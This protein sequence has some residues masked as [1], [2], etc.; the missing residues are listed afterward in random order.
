M[1]DWLT[2]KLPRE[3]L[4]LEA[5]G[6]LEDRAGRVM[7][8]NPDGTIAWRCVMRESVRSDS[9]QLVVHANGLDVVLMGSPARV[10][11]SHN[12]FGSGDIRSCA[13]DMIAFASQHT[14]VTLPIDLSLWRCSRTDVTENY[15]LGSAAEVRQALLFLRSAE[16][17]RYQVRTS[18]E[19]V[20]WSVQSR[21]RSAKAYHK[22]PHLLYLWRKNLCD[23][24]EW[25]REAAQRLLRLE[26]SLK[27][28]W[29]RREPR[30][31]Y[32]WTQAQFG[33]VFDAFF[34]KLVGSVEVVEMDM[35][36]GRFEKVAATKGQALAAYRTW[37]LVKSVGAAETSAS[38]PRPS[39]YRHRKIMFD[40]GLSF[41]DL[42]AGNVVPLRRRPIVLGQP[43]R[44]WGDLGR[45][46][47]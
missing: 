34:S 27:S 18:S 40:A 6:V 21:V 42:Q 33:G 45:I 36:L 23:A 26:L 25:E 28:E 46:A 30:P 3:C 5:Y 13:L 14:G 31:W 44:S 15:D 41:A 11:H 24:T 20:Y 10:V 29:W 19:S 32:E 43:V 39:W 37:S 8:I 38:M 4:G 35:L 9:H 17:G 2:L 7:A 22:G 12:V 16:G 1:I 47:A